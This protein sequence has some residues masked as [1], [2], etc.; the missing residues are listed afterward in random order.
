MILRARAKKKEHYRHQSLPVSRAGSIK[1]VSSLNGGKQFCVSAGLHRSLS[2]SLNRNCSVLKLRL[3]CPLMEQSM[4]ILEKILK[5]LTARD[6]GMWPMSGLDLT[7][8][9]LHF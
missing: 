7:A 5:W 3:R 6:L 8:V 4:D 1:S 9:C 2:D